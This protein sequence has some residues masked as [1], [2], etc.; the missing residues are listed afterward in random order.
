MARPG[1][2]AAVVLTLAV[3]SAGLAWGGPNRNGVLFVHTDESVS[4]T[5]DMTDYCG[6]SGRACPSDEDCPYDADCSTAGLQPTSGRPAAEP[7]VFWVL[8]AFPDGS[9]PRLKGLNFAVDYLAS[10]TGGDPAGIH[11]AGWGPCAGFELPS[12]GWPAPG[13]NVSLVWDATEQSRVLPVYW[14]AAYVEPTEDPADEAQLF[15]L[16]ADPENEVGFFGDDRVPPALDPVEAY[17][18]FGLGGAAGMN[19]GLPTAVHEL[20]WGRLKARF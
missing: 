13:T 6:L 11:V 10:G 14:F 1:S 9:C 3:L 5:S 19:P 12:D 7:V 8:A 4:Y 16:T 15:G 20:S 17:G 18:S 2:S